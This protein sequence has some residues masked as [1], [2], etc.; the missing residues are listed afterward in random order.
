MVKR[1]VVR[2][3]IAGLLCFTALCGSQ[4]SAKVNPTRLHT[5]SFV[6][7]KQLNCLP[8]QS[9][10]AMVDTK[11]GGAGTFRWHYYDHVAGFQ[12]DD[13]NWS[14]QGGANVTDRTGDIGLY[15]AVLGVDFYSTVGLNS[16]SAACT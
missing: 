4:T 2:G 13:H 5:G 16:Y 6:V 11:G 12:Y 7:Y 8:G 10:A 1:V 15:I 14:V 3:V 9:A